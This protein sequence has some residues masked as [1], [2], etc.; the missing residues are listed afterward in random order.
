MNRE[1]AAYAFGGIGIALCFAALGFVLVLTN[2][3]D[4]RERYVALA[5]R[6][7]ALEGRLERYDDLATSPEVLA[8]ALD[9]YW[10]LQEQQQI[11]ELGGSY[12][13]RPHEVVSCQVIRTPQAETRLWRAGL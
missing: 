1:D 11:C 3:K 9:R 10:V 5:A 4:W 2:G 7:A 13:R 8:E 6:T 12:K